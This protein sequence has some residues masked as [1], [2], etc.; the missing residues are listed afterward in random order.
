L[1]GGTC[2]AFPCEICNPGLARAVRS[3]A[4]NQTQNGIHTWISQA[5]V[6]DSEYIVADCDEE[7]EPTNSENPW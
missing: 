5:A 4:V 1:L 6:N 3:E 7:S 2:Q